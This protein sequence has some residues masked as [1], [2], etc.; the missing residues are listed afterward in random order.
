[1]VI[2]AGISGINASY[3]IK[4][5]FPGLSYTILEARNEL[6]GTWSQFQYPG[7]RSDSDLHT[8]GFPWDPWTEERPIADGPSILSYLKAVAAK[9]G[10]AEH[11]E[12][13]H[14]VTKVEWT[15]QEQR[16]TIDVM[17]NGMEKEKTYSALFI[18]MGTGLFDYEEGQSSPIPGIENFEGTVVHPQ[19]WPADL[20][21][22]DKK[23]VIVGSG[24]TAITL[25][26][27]LVD[28]AAAVTM[29][30]RSPTYLYTTP[31]HDPVDG[32]IRRLCPT[33]WVYKALRWKYILG[34]LLFFK[35][36]T[37]FPNAAKKFLRQSIESQLPANVPFDPHFVPSYN[38][39]EQRLCV[40]P[41]GDFF[42]SLRTGKADIVTDHIDTV[43]RAGIVLKSGCRL[44]TDM[45]VT[46]TG[47]KMLLFGKIEILVDGEPV[48][49]PDKF[50]W[51]GA[52][53]QDVPNFF[54]AFGYTNASWT[55]GADTS[56]MLFL[57]V[58][59]EMDRRGVRCVVPML[60]DPGFVKE[61]P[62]LNLSSNYVVRAAKEKR[63]PKGGD[64]APWKPRSSYIQDYLPLVPGRLRI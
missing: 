59:R 63:L 50:A 49:Y 2:G 32:L 6:G 48:D 45:I 36:S 43:D 39:W 58:V 42:A 16:W 21:F 38:P 37:Y 7:I 57:R 54:F 33:R 44:D 46:A 28:R 10:I 51:K 11:I 8:F 27:S 9:H 4:E 26:P 3:R 17:V 13:D 55:L 20:E 18:F 19:F 60:Q 56:T 22:D 64:T 62:W 1:M 35:F 31:E 53:L 12:Y 25:L 34:F 24:A 41:Q 23:T 5:A 29:L 40:T 61:V 52:A 14:R 15:S 47:L 30:Q